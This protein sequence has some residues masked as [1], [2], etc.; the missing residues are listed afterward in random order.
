ML[1]RRLMGLPEEMEV[2]PPGARVNLAISY[3]M[4]PWRVVHEAGHRNQALPDLAIW[5]LHL[6][7]HHGG[8]LWMWYYSL[9]WLKVHIASITEH[10]ADT[11]QPS[12][13]LQ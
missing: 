10:N 3:D 7:R 12:Y 13:H 9:D 6:N 5:E 11:R 1:I 8:C 4:G 2:Q